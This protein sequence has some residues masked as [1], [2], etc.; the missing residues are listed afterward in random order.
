MR[1]DYDRLSYEEQQVKQFQDRIRNQR[2]QH[3]REQLEFEE[4][5]ELLQSLRT[6]RRS[7]RLSGECGITRIDVHKIRLATGGIE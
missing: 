6:Q 3:E 5:R 2:E 1:V 4:Q 7:P